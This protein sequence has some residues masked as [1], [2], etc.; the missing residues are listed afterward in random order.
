MKRNCKLWGIS[1][2]AL[3]LMIASNHIAYSDDYDGIL[4]TKGQDIAQERADEL[5]YAEALTPS[6]KFL[7]GTWLA[8]DGGKWYFEQNGYMGT[9][10]RHMGCSYTLSGDSLTWSGPTGVETYKIKFA[11]NYNQLFFYDM[12]T[13][14][15]LL[16]LDRL[17][18]I[19]GGNNDL[20]YSGNGIPWGGLDEVGTGAGVLYTGGW[21]Y[22]PDTPGTSSEVYVCI[23]GVLGAGQMYGPYTADLIRDDINN[24]YASGRYHGLATAVY[25]EITGDQS[26]YIYTTDYPAGNLTLLGHAQVN[27]PARM[28]PPIPEKPVPEVSNDAEAVSTEQQS[29]EPITEPATESITEKRNIYTEEEAASILHGY[30]AGTANSDGKSYIQYE[31]LEDEHTYVVWW[32]SYT[33][34]TVKLSADLTTGRVMESGPYNGQEPD[35]SLPFSETYA[36]NLADYEQY[37]YFD[38]FNQEEGTVKLDN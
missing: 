7:Y 8:P 27:I 20:F 19:S 38:E 10:G 36:F 3:I 5:S 34:F 35:P 25:T 32:R 22:D 33:A 29:T 12:T 37:R 31:Q 30:C 24:K 1:L 6:I 17:T 4:L 15:C 16:C 21:T 14:S 18:Q 2:T 9:A 13:G 23:G 26:I 28:L 11:A